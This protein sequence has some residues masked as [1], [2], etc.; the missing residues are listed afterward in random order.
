ML[1]SC[2]P[3][4]G[5]SQTVLSADIARAI[6]ASI[7]KDPP[8]LLYTASGSQMSVLGQCDV[9]LSTADSES[10]TKQT[11][12][13]RAI[14]VNSVSHPVLIS[15][16]DLQSLKIISPKFP[17]ATAFSTLCPES[18]KSSLFEQFPTVFRD[19]LLPDPMVG[20]P[21]KIQLKSTAVPFRMSVARQ[22]PLR[23]W[24]VLDAVICTER[25]IGTDRVVKAKSR[26]RM[27]YFPLL[28]S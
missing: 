12:S 23:F 4:T 1:V 28:P 17:T 24:Q 19:S 10:K 25:R 26:S 21:V 16:H 15:W 18:I 11:I 3:D 8:V 2:L 9:L 7:R 5:C 6:G 13:S 20:E 14:I 22:I 27:L